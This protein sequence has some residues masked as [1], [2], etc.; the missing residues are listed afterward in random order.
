MQV[1]Q[2]TKQVA[3]DLQIPS[4][5]IKVDGLNIHYKCL[6]EGPKII[7]LHGG[8]N[9]WQEWR[10]NLAFFARNFQVYAPDL[11]SFG[12]SEPP[13]EPVSLHWFSSFLK[14]FMDVLNITDAHLAAH[15]LGGSI[16]LSFA[17]DSPERVK[18]IVL[19]DSSG[20][21]EISRQGKLLLLL[22]RG[23]KRMF[24][25]EKNP[26]YKDGS[27][28]DWLLVK[29]LRKITSPVMIVW[30]AR[31]PYLPVSHAKLAQSLI[32]NCRL[33]ICAGC[34]HAPHR[35]HADEFNNLAY[36]FLMGKT[37]AQPEVSG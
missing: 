16:A 10:R 6:G 20:L 3:D 32:P 30:G 19:I 4:Y 28:E 8:A 17:L 12:L 7:L 26:K 25:K 18:K 9:D 34:Y 21:G 37:P 31:D 27:L 29:K 33:Y 13:P 23:V 1:K 22:I 2:L 36:Q 15:S 14:N 35:E 11:P 5:W 24:G